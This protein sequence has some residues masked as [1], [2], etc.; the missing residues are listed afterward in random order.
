MLTK[1]DKA[2]AAM[3]VTSIIQI[4][5]HFGIEVPPGVEAIA[6]IVLTSAFVWLVP[7]KAA[8]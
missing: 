8:T 1:F 3:I 2:L 6:T 5:T 7:N 4:V